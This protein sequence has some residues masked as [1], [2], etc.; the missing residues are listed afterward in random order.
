MSLSTRVRTCAAL[1]FCVTTLGFGPAAQ[2]V[3]TR[4]TVG[5]QPVSVI[6]DGNIVHVFHNEVDTD[7]DGVQGEGDYPASWWVLSASTGEVLDKKDFDWGGVGYPF[8]PFVDR[9]NGVVYI[10]NLG[11]VRS[12]SLATQELLGDTV[13]P[14]N[15][16]GVAVHGDQVYVSVRPSFSDPGTL[17]TYNK[18]TGIATERVVGVNPQQI[19][20]FKTSDGTE[21]VLVL[22]EGIF[23]GGTPALLD[24]EFFDGSTAPAALELGATGNHI[25]VKGDTAFVT[26]NGSDAVRIVDIKQWTVVGSISV[27]TEPGNG[28][29]ESVVQGDDLFVSTY[30]GDVRR[31]SVSTGVLRQSFDPGGKPEGIAIVGNLSGNKIWVAN[32]FVKTGFGSDNT[33]AVWDPMVTSVPDGIAP[34]RAAVI[35]S[36]VTDEAE[37]FIPSGGAASG[38]VACTVV[39]ATGQEAGRFR[40][41]QNGGQALQ[42]RFSVARLGLASGR[43]FL[44]VHRDGKA[45]VIP[46]AVAR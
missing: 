1:F 6:A 22:S 15:A 45:M 38:D 28:P 42:V 19:V 4:Y 34:A 20:P 25:F 46:F 11:R 3:D 31:Y 26:I 16:S 8:R 32:A 30:D 33:V 17:V 2:A 40:L 35:P 43:Y 37:L 24:K 36:V 13:A 27:P 29:R 12:F 10:T 44:H 39:T 21:G 7:F 5:L 23:G 41:S 9:E 18:S 14:Y